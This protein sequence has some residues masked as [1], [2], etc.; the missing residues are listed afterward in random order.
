MCA[1]LIGY[2]SLMLDALIRINRSYDDGGDSQPA[3]DNR[4]PEQDLKAIE[5]DGVADESTR[6]GGTRTP[7][8]RFR[9]PLLYPTELLPP[10]TSCHSVNTYLLYLLT[11]LLP[12]TTFSQ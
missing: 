5:S 3:G 8:L 7:D 9:K 10:S 1:G 6:A 12:P 11:F 2:R 4:R